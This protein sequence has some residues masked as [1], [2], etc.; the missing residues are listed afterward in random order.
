MGN[1]LPLTSE[2]KLVEKFRSLFNSYILSEDPQKVSGFDFDAFV[3]SIHEDDPV[4]KQ[5]FDILFQECCRRRMSAQ[6]LPFETPSDNGTLSNVL[7]SFR[8]RH[9]VVPEPE[10][11]SYQR[12]NRSSITPVSRLEPQQYELYPSFF[13]PFTG[14]TLPPIF[15]SPLYSTQPPIPANDTLRDR[16]LSLSQSAE[17]LSS[18]TSNDSS[19][20]RLPFSPL[21]IDRSS[22]TLLAGPEHNFLSLNSPNISNSSS[23]NS[24]TETHPRNIRQN[25][26]NAFYQSAVYRSNPY[27]SENHY[28]SGVRLRRNSEIVSSA[29]STEIRS[30]DF[31]YLPISS[32]SASII[33]PRNTLFPFDPHNNY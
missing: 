24:R 22:V 25:H 8:R 31:P 20:P 32:P 14:S 10:T 23:S 3:N 13:S 1:P 33:P 28:R 12:N 7:Q 2:Q 21:P 5:N 17:F 11:R 26:V 18:H 19:L 4:V 9:S 29:E 6:A 27:S 30:S 16:S 15:Q